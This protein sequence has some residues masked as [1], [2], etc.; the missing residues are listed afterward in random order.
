MLLLVAGAAVVS[1]EQSPMEAVKG[2]ITEVIHVLDDP[3]LA[4]PARSADRRWAIE[5]VL[6][7]HVNYEGMARRSLGASW[8]EISPLEREEFVGLFVEM[9][10]DML[11]GRLNEYS[12]EQIVYLSER[13]EGDFAEVQTVWI[14]GKVVTS[15]DV[16]LAKQTG[17][18]LMYDA[19]IDEESIV[20]NYHAQFARIIRDDL[21]AGLVSRMKQKT[22]LVKAFEHSVVR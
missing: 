1:A 5:E 14:G 10:R 7:N 11:A 8:M 19:V 2:V 20:G 4:M 9:L 15:F 17:D 22:M 12:S 18:W 21:Y 13:R 16:R 6:R 3:A